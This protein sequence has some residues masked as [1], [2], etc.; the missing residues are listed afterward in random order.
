[1]STVT[2]KAELSDIPEETFLH[3]NPK[4]WQ[5]S[6]FSTPEKAPPRSYNSLCGECEYDYILVL[7]YLTKTVRSVEAV[8]AVKV[9]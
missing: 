8:Q 7:I 6:K 9:G 5:L 2:R 3:H 1:M 4:A